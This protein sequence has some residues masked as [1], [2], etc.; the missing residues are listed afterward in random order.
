MK[1]N[2]HERLETALHC[3]N[4]SQKMDLDEA[5]RMAQY[6]VEER[7]NSIKLETVLT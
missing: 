6:Q 4:L 1:E 7:F 3:L 2:I 5:V